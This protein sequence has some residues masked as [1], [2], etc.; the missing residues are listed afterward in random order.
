[1]AA[2]GLTVESAKG[3]C[4]LGQHEIAFRYDEALTTCDQHVVYKTGAKEIA[5]Q[6]GVSLTFMAKYDER[7]GNSCHIHLSLARRG[8]HAGVRRPATTGRH[9]AHDA[10]L[11]GRT[12]RRAARTHPAVRAQRQLLQALPPRLLRPHRRRLG[13]ATTAPARCASSATATRCASRTG[14][15]GG[16][17]NPYLAVAAHGRRRTARH[18]TGT[19]TPR[20]V[21]RQ[22]LPRRRTPHVPATLRE[23][24]DALATA[25]PSPATPSATTSSSTTCNMARVEQDA[26]DSRRHRLGAA[27]APSSACED[28]HRA[29]RTHPPPSTTILNPATE[30]VLATVP[31]TAPDQVDAAVARAAAAQTGW[32]AAAPGRPGPPAAPL[33]RRRG[34]RT[35]RSSPTW[36]SARPATPIGN[37]RWEAGNVRD[38]LDYAAGGVGA[39]QRRA[40]SRCPAD[41]TS[42]STNRSAWSASSRPGTSRCPSPP[43]PAPRRSPPATPSCSSPP[44]PP[45]SPRCGW[46]NSPWRPDCPSTSSRCCPAPD[47]SPERA[48]VDH[49]GRREDR[50]HRLHRRRQGRSWPAAPPGSSGSPSNSAARAPTSSSPT[51]TWNGPPPPP[52]CPSWTTPA[53]TAAPAPASWCSAPSTTGSWNCSRPPSRPSPSATPPTRPPQMGPLISAAQ[54]RPGALL[55]PRGRPGGDPRQGPRRARASGSR[56]PSS[57]TSTPT[58]PRPPRRSSGRSPS[59]CPST[60]RPTRSASPTP[61]P[62][63]LSGSLWTRDVGRALRVSRAVRGRATSPSTRT[64]ACATGPRSAASSSPDSAANWARTR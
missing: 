17:V 26:Y 20:A 44:R 28:A 21:H 7:E 11:P 34:R 40:R 58:R 59:C 45:R 10:A 15:P 3:E 47:R 56:P 50:L 2:A 24:A 48:L 53:R 9:V 12:A 57:P 29:R 61:P 64:A 63:G 62:Y 27:S 38:L 39:A 16:D 8:R 37:A 30:E 49:P 60:T 54:P 55:R 41:W 1:M 51:P 19:R 43:G 46:P 23:A 5:A 31:A 32:A 33:R 13:T 35:A 25:A 42:P 6:E 18:R 14:C 22:R 4:N 36:R 52:R